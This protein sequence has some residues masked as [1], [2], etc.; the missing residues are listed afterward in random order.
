MKQCASFEN[1]FGTLDAHLQPVSEMCLFPLPPLSND[2][3]PSNEPSSKLLSSIFHHQTVQCEWSILY[4]TRS[5]QSTSN[6]DAFNSFLEA[7]L[8][9]SRK[10]SNGS[11]LYNMHQSYHLLAPVLFQESSSLCRISRRQVG[12]AIQ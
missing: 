9:R 3:R 5:G 8:V 1:R 2:Q 4:A 7:T 11:S 12:P 10:K 6:T